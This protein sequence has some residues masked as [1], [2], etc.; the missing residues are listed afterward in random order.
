[1]Y[2]KAQLALKFINYYLRA[3]NGRGHGIHSPFVFDF[4]TKLLNDRQLY[5]EY[6]IAEQL[7]TGMKSDKRQVQVE[8]FGAGSAL[9]KTNQR[10]I[11]S[12]AQ[13]AAKP[14]KLGQLLFRTV[15]KYQPQ[16]IVELGTSLGITTTYLSLAKPDA[17]LITLEGAGEIANIA[18]QNFESLGLKNVELIK[19]NFDISLPSVLDKLEKI[20]FAF[21]DGNHR[22]K[23]TENYFNLMLKKTHPGSILIFDDI[24]WSAEME[25]AWH[26]I[27][28]HPSVKCSIDLFFLGF[29]FFRSEFKERQEFV[30]RF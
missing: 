23:P 21:I 1:M 20:D 18:A 16:T 5:P 3:G 6:S 17:K 24:H 25:A 12:I 19:G 13:H 11:S 15:K 2:S 14:P 26:T 28:S 27:K 10:R 29:I 4:I 8:D 7:R 30:I 9:S 22:Q